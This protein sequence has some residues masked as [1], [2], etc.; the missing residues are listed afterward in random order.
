MT[1]VVPSADCRYRVPLGD[2]ERELN[3]QMKALHSSD[4]QPLQ[5]A[6]MSNLIIYC[7]GLEQSIDINDQVPAISYAH[8]ARVILLVAEAAWIATIEVTR[9][10]AAQSHLAVFV[11]R[12]RHWH[13]LS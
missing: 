1:D 9:N 3:R 4:G 10:R 13:L 8:P 2:V 11:P 6:R 7:T 12:N 5:R